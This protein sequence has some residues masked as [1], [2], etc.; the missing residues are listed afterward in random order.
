MRTEPEQSLRLNVKSISLHDIALA[1][2]RL[3]ALSDC[4]RSARTNRRPLRSPW[5]AFFDQPV[6]L[7]DALLLLW[8]LPFFSGACQQQ[9]SNGEL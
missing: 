4:E 5:S 8:S 2:S 7:N 9:G 1:G 3:G 6:E